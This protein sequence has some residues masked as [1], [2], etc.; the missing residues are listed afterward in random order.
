MSQR[1]QSSSSKSS[2]NTTLNSRQTNSGKNK[3]MK[4]EFLTKEEEY[5][6]LNDELEKK[7]ANLVYEAEQVLKAN[8][9]LFQE[10]NLIGKISEVDYKTFLM[11]E[12]KPNEK[13]TNM[14]AGK[15][16]DLNELKSFK[17][18]IDNIELSHGLKE[19]G[20]YNAEEDDDE[21]ESS[22]MPKVANEM[23]NDAQIRFL[24]AK[25]K[26]LQEEID[27]VANELRKKEE[28]NSKLAQRCKELDED[29]GKQLR[30]SNSHQT[31]MEKYKKLNEELESKLTQLD[32][33]NSVLKK[34][35]EQLKRDMKKNQ[36]DQQQ[37][38]LKLNRALE[39]IEK[40][41]VQL[42]KSKVDSKDTK[43][44]EKK[45]LEQLGT[46]NKRLQKQKLELIQAF[47]K[48]L[49][50]ID[51]LKKQKMHLEAA[52][53][54]QFSEE[55]FINAIEL[56]PSNPSTYS[57]NSK[58]IEKNSQKPKMNEISKPNKIEL[59]EESL[60]KG[61]MLFEKLEEVNF[62]EE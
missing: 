20:E 34:E 50:L 11:D 29:R 59:N 15:F 46:E 48:Q 10:V 4:N 44:Q 51:V 2:S 22:V 43:D 16:M 23:S 49:K 61:E 31:Q 60:N 7:T 8:E 18:T 19:K 35:N 36:V 12:E 1:Q 54:L 14:N 56:N 24:K 25:L 39:E 47:K 33:Q 32:Q 38:E 26:V 55:E 3:E 6:R 9:K 40:L 37:G 17:K 27:K 53:L 13:R 42:D 57:A 21:D 62:D 52:R 30:I 5:K 45:R 41:K 58:P 28:E